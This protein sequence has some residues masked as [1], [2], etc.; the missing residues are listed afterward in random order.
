MAPMTSFSSVKFS[1][2][3]VWQLVCR[4]TILTSRELSNSI[5]LVDFQNSSF[6]SNLMP[7]SHSSSLH[8]DTEHL[9]CVSLERIS[10]LPCI[11][12]IDDVINPNAKK[13]AISTPFLG[14]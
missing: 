7:R 4:P 10:K 11:P 3:V 13:T 12:L 2:P 1:L 8:S 5:F 14:I 9:F 6:Y